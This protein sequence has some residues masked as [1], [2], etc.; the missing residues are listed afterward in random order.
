MP[1]SPKPEAAPRDAHGGEG[2]A[3]HAAERVGHIAV[4]ERDELMYAL[5][6]EWL[7]G[8]GYG[9]RDSASPADPAGAVDLVIVSIAL[10]KEESDALLRRV[11][12]VHSGSPV[13]VLTSRARAGLSSAGA[14]ARGLGVERVMAKPLTRAEL[15]AAVHNI[16]GRPRP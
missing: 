6:R 14:A 11:R 8:A 2:R 7:S 5:L 13:I 1:S 10:P 9:V 4:Y 16:V 3:A 15:L 12:A